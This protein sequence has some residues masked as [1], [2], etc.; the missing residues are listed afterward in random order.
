MDGNHCRNNFFPVETSPAALSGIPKSFSALSETSSYNKS[1]PSNLDSE[2]GLKGGDIFSDMGKQ[3]GAEECF[4]GSSPAVGKSPSESPLTSPLNPV[5]ITQDY[6]DLKKKAVDQFMAFTG[7][8]G[9]GKK[10]RQKPRKEVVDS[11]NDDSDSLYSRNT[12]DGAD[13]NSLAG[14]SMGKMEEP[15]EEGTEMRKFQPDGESVQETFVQKL[16]KEISYEI[17]KAKAYRKRMRPYNKEVLKRIQ[18]IIKNTF[19]GMN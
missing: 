13:K 5:D 16:N 14:E 18:K 10:K 4:A 9:I 6:Q 8:A 19:P 11:K 1:I 2:G 3:E 12:E 7:S 17:H 15:E